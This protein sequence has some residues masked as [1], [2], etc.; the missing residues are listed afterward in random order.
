MS[1]NF[2]NS[3]IKSASDQVSHKWWFSVGHAEGAQR[4]AL[5]PLV[6]PRLPCPWLPCPW[7]P[8]S[9]SLLRVSAAAER[10]VD[11]K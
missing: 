2:L 7:L 5:G 1:Q 10:I 4:W 9:C 11:S 8:C 6:C 3:L